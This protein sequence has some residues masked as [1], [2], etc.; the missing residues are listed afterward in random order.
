[1]KASLSLACFLATSSAFAAIGDSINPSGQMAYHVDGVTINYGGTYISSTAVVQAESTRL[2]DSHKG[3]PWT[4][5][6]PNGTEYDR[7]MCWTHVAT[8]SIQYWQDV[9]GVFYKDTGNKNAT[10]SSSA[11]NLPNG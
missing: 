7:L 5:S 8:N 1:M 6:Y 3:G 10:D 9:Y 11:R 4:G 2:Y